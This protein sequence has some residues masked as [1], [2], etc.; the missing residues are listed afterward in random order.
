MPVGRKF[1]RHY[2]EDMQEVFVIMSGEAEIRVDDESAVLHPGDAVVI[3]ARA[4]HEMSNLGATD[5]LYLALGITGE[6]GG[7]TVVV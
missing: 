2:H 3:D 4:V 5:V 6:A 1:A 7:K